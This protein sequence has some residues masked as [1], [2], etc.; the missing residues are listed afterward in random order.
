MNLQAVVEALE[1]AALIEDYFEIN[2]SPFDIGPGDSFVLVDPF[3]VEANT[4][5]DFKLSVTL[6]SLN[7]LTILGDLVVQLMIDEAVV[8]E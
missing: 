4:V 6:F 3:C 7:G 1:A 8:A 2:S 5:L